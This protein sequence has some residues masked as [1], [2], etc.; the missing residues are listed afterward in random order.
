MKHMEDRFPL[1][2]KID[3][4]NDRTIMYVRGKRCDW[5]LTARREDLGAVGSTQA[6]ST[7]HLEN[8]DEEGNP[9]WRSHCIDN[10]QSNA[11][12]GDQFCTR[13]LATMNDDTLSQRTILLTINKKL[14]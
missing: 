11:S 3:K 1:Q 10:T 14:E 8:I 9:L 7:E 2:I 13:A 5:R 4:N 12:V 6:V